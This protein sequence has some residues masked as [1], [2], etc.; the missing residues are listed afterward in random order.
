MILFLRRLNPRRPSE[1]RSKMRTQNLRRNRSALPEHADSTPATAESSVVTGNTGAKTAAESSGSSS[2][3][4]G[5]KR[6]IKSIGHFLHIG[7]RKER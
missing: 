7:R 4:S 5:V 2:Y 1:S 6:A 3:D